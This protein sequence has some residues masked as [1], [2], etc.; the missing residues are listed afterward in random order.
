MATL[1][2]LSVYEWRVDA[3]AYEPGQMFPKECP[4]A[5]ASKTSAELS[6]RLDYS[7]ETQKRKLDIIIPTISGSVIIPWPFFQ[8]EPISPLWMKTPA[9]QKAVYRCPG[10]RRAVHRD[11][12]VLKGAIKPETYQSDWHWMLA[13]LP[14]SQAVLMKN[15][16][17]DQT[18]SGRRLHTYIWIVAHKKGIKQQPTLLSD[19]GLCGI[20]CI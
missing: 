14:L 10:Q 15:L 4:R 18:S 16:S 13:W 19:T 7:N 17:P 2:F 20:Y 5:C 6:F 11:A 9:Q 1:H 3:S 8:S 12:C